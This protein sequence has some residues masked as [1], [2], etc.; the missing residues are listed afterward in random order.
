MIHSKGKKKINFK[1]TFIRIVA[2]T[3]WPLY[4]LDVNNTFLQCDLQEEVYMN[5]PRGFIDVNC[6]FV[7][8]K[9]VCKLLKSLYELK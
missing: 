7:K 1:A 9:K 4:Q 6:T 2:V 8:K 5:V 3:Q